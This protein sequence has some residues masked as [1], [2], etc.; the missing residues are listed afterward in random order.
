MLHKVP[1]T[2]SL[3]VFNYKQKIFARKIKKQAHK[4]IFV[5]LRFARIR[6]GIWIQ[7]S[8][9]CQLQNESMREFRN[10]QRGTYTHM[11]I[12][13]HASYWARTSLT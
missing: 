3:V 12:H 13:A 1:D 9:G 8:P 4:Y 5:R 6:R 2:Q 10:T 11:Y 7:G